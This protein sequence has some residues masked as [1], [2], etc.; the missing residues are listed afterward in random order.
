VRAC[1][2]AGAPVA[3]APTGVTP[4]RK[5]AP[6]AAAAAGRSEA[7]RDAQVIVFVLAPALVVLRAT[8]V[9]GADDGPHVAG[10]RRHLAR[11]ALKPS[12]S[13]LQE[14]RASTSHFKR[15][16]LPRTL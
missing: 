11:A 14:A 8:R 16:L 1:A 4:K 3:C 12:W 5:S 13:R 2:C 10:G 9:V 7:D 15:K 6:R